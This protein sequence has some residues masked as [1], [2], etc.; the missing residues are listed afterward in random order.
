M[1]DRTETNQYSDMK[2]SMKTGGIKEVVFPIE[3]PIEIMM[4][5]T[6]E[7]PIIKEVI[8]PL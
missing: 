7:R 6:I 1:N 2:S 5:K 4:E 8:Y 3:V